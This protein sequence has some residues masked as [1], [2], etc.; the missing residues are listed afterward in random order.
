MVK[1][2]SDIRKQIK[3]ANYIPHRSSIFSNMFGGEKF[4]KDYN[5]AI[6]NHCN[7]IMLKKTK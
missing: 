1:N 5:D 2:K 6:D 3:I 4:I 7:L